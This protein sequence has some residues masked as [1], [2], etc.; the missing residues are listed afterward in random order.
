MVPRYLD[1]NPPVRSGVVNYLACAQRETLLLALQMTSGLASPRRG[2][3]C[4]AHLALGIPILYS[5]DRL[6]CAASTSL[7]SL[8]SITE[9]VNCRGVGANVRSPFQCLL[10]CEYLLVSVL[11]IL[12]TRIQ[13]QGLLECLT[14]VSALFIECV[15]LLVDPSARSAGSRARGQPDCLT[16]TSGLS[17]HSTLCT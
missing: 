17:V 6:R 14:H 9:T 7:S 3:F 12:R 5:K 11:S 13:T 10:C 15:E 1:R 4:L 8:P 16:F 2:N